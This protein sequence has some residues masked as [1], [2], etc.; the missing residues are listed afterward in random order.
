MLRAGGAAKR[1]NPSEAG[2]GWAALSEIYTELTANA[3]DRLDVAA[4]VAPKAG[5]GAPGRWLPEVGSIELDGNILPKDPDSLDI[6][7]NT[8]DRKAFAAL[9][10][11]FWHELGH[12]QHTVWPAGVGDDEDD[13][14]YAALTLLEEVRME[15][16]V[17][18]STPAKAPW[19]RAAS[20]QLLLPLVDASDI[21]MKGLARITALTIGRVR[22]GSLL[23]E[24]CKEVRR[25]LSSAVPAPTLKSLEEILS[26]VAECGD[27]EVEKFVGL[28]KEWLEACDVDGHAASACEAKCEP[29]GPGAGDS[30]E[31]DTPE[32]ME[33]EKAEDGTPDDYYDPG[34][35]ERLTDDGDGSALKEALEEALEEVAVLSEDSALEE[36]GEEE[37]EETAAARHPVK[38][39]ELKLEGSE[40][41]DKKSGGDY[42]YSE[43]GKRSWVMRPPSAEEMARRRAL[44][45]KLRMA[46]TRM[47]AV[48]TKGSMLPPGRL[49]SRGALKEHAEQALGRLPSATP[50]KRKVRKTI[51]SPKLNLGICMDISGS[52]REA[53][54]HISSAMW[55]LGQAV[56]DAGG[57]AVGAVFGFG[58]EM[59][60][61]ST[62]KKLSSHV[63]DFEAHDGTESIADCLEMVDRELGLAS[64]AGGS[65]AS[66]IVVISDCHWL[67]PSQSERAD[68]WLAKAKSRGIKTVAVGFGPWVCEVCRVAYHSEHP[69][70]AE[71]HM[72]SPSEFAGTMGRTLVEVLK[73]R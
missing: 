52:M 72:E 13:E 1:V 19:L 3:L 41:D 68:Q 70:D 38:P 24:D 42:G 59:V 21:S 64:G 16:R 22:A 67:D 39:E 25:L 65:D 46:R 20:R 63:M 12:A 55:V 6:A 73:T 66:V 11:V 69:F 5:G 9:H 30:G 4:C 71:V 14:L 32:E 27:E 37:W 50:W 40:S 29:G 56:K 8:E 36:I 34:S 23:E 48:T 44:A 7:G 45:A 49:D 57:E 2:P 61:D 33:R 60:F 53:A 43:F 51:E 31:F 54:P 58:T 35:E 15:A 10:G 62:K 18:E 28:G 47:R 26:R 17:I